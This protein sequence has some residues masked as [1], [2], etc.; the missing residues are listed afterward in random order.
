MFTKI[1]TVEPLDSEGQ[2]P[3]EEDSASSCLEVPGTETDRPLTALD[4]ASFS[5]LIHHIS[6]K[7]WRGYAWVRLKD[8]DRILEQRIGPKSFAT[9]PLA[10]GWLRRIGSE[11]GFANFQFVIQLPGD[12]GLPVESIRPDGVVDTLVPN[13][14]DA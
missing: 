13:D 1:V 12:E 6:D 7:D 4:G 3:F 10:R 2:T 11:R 5:A 8:L 14:V 9:M